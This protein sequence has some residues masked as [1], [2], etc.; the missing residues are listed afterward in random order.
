MSLTDAE[1]KQVKDKVLYSEIDT[2]FTKYVEG[3]KKVT[4]LCNQ[5]LSGHL[6]TS[7]DGLNV[8]STFNEGTVNSLSESSELHFLEVQSAIDIKKIAIENWQQSNDQVRKDIEN[9]VGG[10]LPELKNI[11]FRLRSRIAK[12]QA[13]YDSVKSINQEF[14]TLATGKTN[15]AVSQEEWEHE[16][17]KDITDQLI[18]QNHLKIE[19]RYSKQERLGVYEDFSNGPKE[20]KRLNNAMK[21]DITKL[22]K[23]IDV[24]K[25]K[26][27]KDADIFSKITNV[28]QDELSKRDVQLSGTDID[29][30][31]NEE[32]EE[33]EEDETRKN[34]E[35]GLLQR[36]R[37]S[38]DEANHQHSD[39]YSDEENGQVS[40]TANMSGNEDQDI[41]MAEEE[42]E[43]EEDREEEGS[44]TENGSEVYDTKDTLVEPNLNNELIQSE[45]IDDR[46][47]ENSAVVSEQEET[48]DNSE[49]NSNV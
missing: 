46:T 42:D 2:S 29:M 34:T 20:A 30:E 21:S 37:Y 26:W 10:T 8:N 13:L 38:E 44:R 1:I 19:S 48:G 12:I 15:L 31:G 23:E 7:E 22:T 40:E 14:N 32:S 41:E 9:N 39:E 25:N 45:D 17:G 18:K 27:L 4:T 35:E 43:E 16:L 49:P 11:H 36:Q 24:Y 6:E 28:L 33:D 47:Q 5:L 3:V